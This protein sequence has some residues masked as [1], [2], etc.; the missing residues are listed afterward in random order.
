MLVLRDCRLHILPVLVLQH[1]RHPPMVPSHIYLTQALRQAAALFYIVVAHRSNRTTI[2]RLLS[3]ASA[4]QLFTYNSL[5]ASCTSPISSPVCAP[6]PFPLLVTVRLETKEGPPSSAPPAA[7]AVPAPAKPTPAAV[8]IHLLSSLRRRLLRGELPAPASA[9]MMVVV[10]V[11]VVIIASVPPAVVASTTAAP[12]VV[13]TPVVFA[14]LP[15]RRVAR[16]VR[17]RA[18]HVGGRRRLHRRRVVERDGAGGVAGGQGGGVA[19]GRRGVRAGR[20]VGRRV[21]HLL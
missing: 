11:V 7:R 16:G 3:L 12:P 14:R 13:P 20:G 9:V 6:F 10:V 18:R 1:F 4:Y 17:A 15:D 2:S 19:R 5:S 21:G 8:L